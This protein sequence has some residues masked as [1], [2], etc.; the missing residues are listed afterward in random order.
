[1]VLILLSNLSNISDENLKLLSQKFNFGKGGTTPR[2]KQ[3]DYEFIEKGKK[4]GP[5]YQ[6]VV[7]A[8][9]NGMAAIENAFKNIEVIISSM[10]PKE[11]S[12]PEIL[13]QS[14]KNIISK[15]YFLNFLRN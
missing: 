12:Q 3:I 6:S 8:F 13:N 2:D 14:R 5:E 15:G 11:K 7:D 4:L 10:T 1:M 9:D